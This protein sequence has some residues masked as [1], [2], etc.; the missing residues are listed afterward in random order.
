[1]LLLTWFGFWKWV[2]GLFESYFGLMDLPNRNVNILFIIIGF[3]GAIYW[4]IR[5]I[6]YNKKA[7]QQGTIK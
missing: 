4:I 7:E 3:V 6:D 2:Q 5:Q 1:M